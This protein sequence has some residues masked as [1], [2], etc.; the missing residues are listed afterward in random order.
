[1]EHMTVVNTHAAQ[2]WGNIQ[3][4]Y[5]EGADIAVVILVDMY[6]E[7][8]LRGLLP[9]VAPLAAPKSHTA[10]LRLSSELELIDKPTAKFAHEV[11]R[12]RKYYQ[13]PFGSAMAGT[14]PRTDKEP[15]EFLDDL[16]RRD[17]LLAVKILGIFMTC[18][19]IWFASVRK[20]STTAKSKK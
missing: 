9:M 5:T 3:S 10:L 19:F 18:I 8:Q 11:R 7:Q 15:H 6:I 20:H 2:V 14:P 1:M 4:A 16:A 17:A 12:L 13:Q